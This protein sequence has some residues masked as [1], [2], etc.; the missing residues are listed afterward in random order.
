MC[1]II[2]Y[3]GGRPAT[4]IV[5][6]SLKLLEYRGYDSTGVAI[7]DEGDDQ[8]VVSKTEKKVDDLIGRL[9][10]SMPLGH[11]GI[12]HTRWA[13]HGRP[14]TLNAHPHHD[15]HGRI[16]VVHNGI[17]ENFTE[18]RDE[19]QARGHEFVSDTDSEIVPHLIEDSYDGDLVEAV[20]Q[21]LRR[22]HG[23]Y[24]LAIFSAAEPDLLVGARLNAPLVVGL[25]EGEW[26][27]SSDITAV[28][29]YTRRVLV[30]DEGEMV[31]ITPAGPVV[32]DLDGREVAPRIIT[33]D[34]DVSQAQKGGYAHYTLKEIHEQPGALA[35]VVR[36]RIS[37]SG[38]VS[39]AEFVATDRQLLDHRNVKL[40]G[41]GSSQFAALLGTYLIESWAGIPAQSE[42]ASEFRY[43]D[44]VLD[45]H[46]LAVVITQSGETAD[47][48]AALRQ[49]RERGALT[50]AVTNVV[51]S[52]VTRESSGVIYLNCGPEIGVL[53]TKSLTST[54]TAL[55]LL[56]L[57]LAAVRH[58]LAPEMVDEIVTGLAELPSR[59]ERV[60][61]GESELA[62]LA[63]RYT[64]RRNFMFIG[65]GV[66]LPVA[67]EGAL[68]LKECSYVH[69]EG[70]AAGELKHGAIAL[71]DSSLPVVAIATA[72]SQYDKV[73]SNIHES[74]ARDAPAI[75][76]VTRGDRRVRDIATDVFEMDP[77]PEWLSP[78]PN[79]VALQLFAYHFACALGRDVD[80]PRNL[81]KS[82]T[83]E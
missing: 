62:A 37:A 28:I 66:N 19:L 13:T 68:K 50:L 32:T 3:L 72:G 23:A 54:V 56:A 76:L 65:R 70:Y 8:P 33:V 26:F 1:G 60:L 63:R 52:S 27:L 5:L 36:G 12:G 77:C 2:G 21:A 75:A 42:L 81:A 59:V 45:E 22:I 11:L 9:Q 38:E 20:R 47:T 46:T 29:P 64:D 74:I 31:A 34:W 17:I 18:L 58:R 7:L 79:I 40:V 51:G 49:A 67:L 78:V 4:P 43:R 61:A 48:L 73:V 15:C 10:E 30:L 69:A 14:T 39:F 80:Q 24:A 35:N 55:Y 53:A 25:G 83:V 6:D 41:M 16:M 44:P 82:V 57:R 71:L